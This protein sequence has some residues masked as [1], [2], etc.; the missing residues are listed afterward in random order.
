[1]TTATA[2]TINDHLVQLG[3]LGDQKDKSIQ[4]IGAVIID[5]FLKEYEEDKYIP[6]DDATAKLLHYLTDTQVRDYAMGLL[7]MYDTKQTLDALNFLLDKAPT[8][9]AF[10]NA[11]ACLLATFLCERGDSASAAVTLSNVSGYYPLALLLGRVMKAG[12]P[13]SFFARMRNETHPKVVAGIFGDDYEVPEAGDPA[14]A[15]ID[16]A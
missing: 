4:R 10:I 13:A 15:G 9:T 1:M 5:L 6:T 7:G 16:G 14:D 3:V 11:P 2:M 8:D 12:V